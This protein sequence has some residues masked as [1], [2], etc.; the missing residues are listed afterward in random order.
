[1]KR[2]LLHHIKKLSLKLKELITSLRER[3]YPSQDS[4]QNTYCPSPES[5][6]SLHKNWW[7]AIGHRLSAISGYIN[8]YL[9]TLQK[10][11]SRI[12]NYRI[13]VII[14]KLHL[15]ISSQNFLRIHMAVIESEVSTVEKKLKELESCYSNANICNKEIKNNSFS[16]DYFSDAN[17]VAEYIKI[18]AE[19]IEQNSGE[20]ALE[21]PEIVNLIERFKLI[22]KKAEKIKVIFSNLQNCQL[23]SIPNVVE[24]LSY[25]IGVVHDTLN[26]IK[27]NESIEEMRETDISDE[28]EEFLEDIFDEVEKISNYKKQIFNR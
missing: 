24:S 18:V 25:L 13:K 5:D 21:K 16:R 10:N 1:M 23:E 22:A 14:T 9:N 2:D 27:L 6:E 7:Q 15:A 3:G 11:Y 12:C 17:R 28:E 19:T 26:I 4:P 8:N 20:I